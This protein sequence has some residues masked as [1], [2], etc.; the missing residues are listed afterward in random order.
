VL[1]GGYQAAVRLGV[2][3]TAEVPSPRDRGPY[4]ASAWQWP[5]I[6]IDL[7]D[8]WRRD[9]SKVVIDARSPAR[10]AGQE[11]T[12]D[13]VAGH[14]PGAVSL[15]YRSLVG[16]NGALLAPEAIAARL[17]E[18]IG[19]RPSDAVAV[20]CGSGVTACHLILAMEHAGFGVPRLYVGSWSEWCRS[21]R[22]REPAERLDR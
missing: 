20:H 3:T 21:R 14:I 22:P 12:I 15:F 19:E 1:D 11:E 18:V 17:R 5:T 7:I 6:D 16:A 2:A 13:P 8:A 9:P 10:F 4:P